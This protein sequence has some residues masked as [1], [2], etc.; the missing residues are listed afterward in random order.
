[1]DTDKNESASAGGP[2]EQTPSE[3]AGVPP[4]VDEQI[5]DESPKPDAG[6][7]HA[8]E[9]SLAAANA[10]PEDE[11]EMPEAVST[12]GGRFAKLKNLGHAYWA[13]KKWTLPVTALALIVLLLAVPATRYPI[14]GLVWKKNISIAVV[15]STTSQPVTGASVSLAGKSAQTDNKGVATVKIAV[16]PHKLTVSKKYY[17][18][19]TATA[20]A[21]LFGTSSVRTN[22]V[23]T[24]RQVPVTV[25]D[26]ITG[27][28]IEN[29]VLKAAGT[30]AKT[31]KMG[32]ATLVLPT[33]STNQ[34]ATITLSGYNQQKVNVLVTARVVTTNNFTITP[35]G[36]LYFLSNQSGKI[37]VVKTDLDGKNRK[38][39]LAGTGKEDTYTTALLASRDWKYLA[40][41]SK[42]DG[43]QG[44]YLIDTS[45]DNVTNID[46]GSS[47]ATFTLV[48]WSGDTFVYEV[49]RSNI[50]SWQSGA[51]AIKSYDASSAKLYNI[52]QTTGEG[53][54]QYDYGSTSFSIVSILNGELAYTKNWGSSSLP[55]HLTGKSDSL[56]TV[57]PDGSSKK[58]AKDFPIPD[59]QQYYYGINVSQYQPYSLYLQVP[60]ND[61]TNTYYEYEN[62]SVAAKSDV[63]DDTFN[64]TYPTYL[65]SPS[66]KLTFWT[67]VR[68]NKNTLFVGD[69]SGANGKQVA[70]LS[71]YVPYGWYSDSYLLV[72]KNGSELYAMPTDGSKPP[73]K[74]T[75]YYKPQLSYKGY[76]GGYGGL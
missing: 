57:K 18:T 52:D 36:K 44:V 70:S 51:T 34:D 49:S 66:S 13:R 48:G 38:T 75:D 33:T 46:G 59:G 35:T 60:N 63:T 14:L 32:K 45:S 6:E 61:G 72:S 9:P 74:I 25:T 21:K 47:Q 64:K 29:A 7:M 22:L 62:G 1:M 26:Y 56:V 4:M 54:G 19:F 73:V 42:R 37:D 58:S 12:P 27:K 50:Q 68:D 16:G 17:K 10:T 55:S 8:V 3:P 43:Q 28:P 30:T 67:E 5:T 31:D 65:V 24:G 20:T 53:T 71:D 69:T 76:G 23:A 15:D 41:L 39:V 40:L 11:T 2:L